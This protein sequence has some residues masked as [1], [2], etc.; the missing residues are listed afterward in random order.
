MREIATTA[1]LDDE[2]SYEGTA[3]LSPPDVAKR[4]AIDRLADA[5]VERNFTAAAASLIAS[6]VT[7]PSEARR[8]LQVPSVMRVP[9]A[10]IE[11][12]NVSVWAPAISTYP[13]NF[14]EAASHVYPITGQVMRHRPLPAPRPGVGP[15][16]KL[17][18]DNRDQ[19]IA[20]L[21]QS[22]A[23]L[24][25]HNDYRDSIGLQGVLM[26]VI[27]AVTEIE[28]ADG[29]PP[30]SLA[31]SVDGSSRVASSHELLAVEPVD[32]AYLYPSNDR[33]YRQ[34]IGSVRALLNRPL[35]TLTEAEKAKVRALVIPASIIV[36]I[37]H[38]PETD[39][40]RVIGSLVG[41]IHVDPPRQWD[42]GA[43]LDAQ[44]DSA[45]QELSDRELIT[46][47]QHDFFAGLI[48]REE[49]KHAGLSNELDERGIAILRVVKDHLSAAKAGIRRL[50]YKRRYE[51]GPL[52]DM[53]AELAI[54]P[55]RSLVSAQAA[56]TSRAGLQRIFRSDRFTVTPRWRVTG[57]SPEELRD[58]ALSEVDGGE[59]GA[60]SAELALLAAY[61]L[62]R[63]RVLRRPDRQY[64]GDIR[65]PDVILKKMATSRH[66]VLTLYQAL[67]D[68][69][70]GIEPRT[71]DEAGVPV[72]D[73]TNQAVT[74]TA[75]WLRGDLVPEP[76]GWQDEDGVTYEPI[77]FD[78]TPETV[79][80]KHRAN[81]ARH[82]DSLEQ[83]I[84]AL[85]A[86]TG[87]DGGSA[88]DEHGWPA[89]EAD[90]HLRRLEQIKERLYGWKMQWNIKNT[91]ERVSTAS[92]EA[93]S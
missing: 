73:A 41:L 64:L 3:L 9:E 24:L 31:S 57:R 71:V 76:G 35:D 40:A 70:S 93:N 86:V 75:K 19:L 69:R 46:G 21:N 83:D 1:Q 39:S 5:L 44:A 61:H 36:G 51:W 23:F 80:A 33:R 87:E 52:A 6:A 85:R 7:D 72:L 50:I 53:C 79:M 56:T 25:E 2:V 20:S 34:T 15:S 18:V 84:D 29:T 62:T 37:N 66:G 55:Y 17:T 68:G 58:A 8:R 14:R 60:D 28:H 30:T 54:R 45:L 81:F 27:V 47:V 16:L 12:I 90:E 26:P 88:V 49:A 67:I 91:A 38:G 59:F 89:A 65:E 43:T 10:T 63:Y 22:E 78:E 32:I 77:T 48:T 42:P 13:A 92:E 4:A 82:L 74:M 11:Y